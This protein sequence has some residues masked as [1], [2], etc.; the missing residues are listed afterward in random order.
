M[1]EGLCGS[2]ERVKMLY[3]IEVYEIKVE[4]KKEKKKGGMRSKNRSCP[5]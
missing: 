3:V 2:I 5:N 1:A 4:T